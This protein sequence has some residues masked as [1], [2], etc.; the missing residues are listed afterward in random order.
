[1]LSQDDSFF[2]QIV[3]QL[4]EE[5]EGSET[6]MFLVIVMMKK[7]KVFVS[8]DILSPSLA[9]SSVCSMDSQSASLPIS[10][11]NARA[12]SLEELQPSKLVKDRVDVGESCTTI[13]MG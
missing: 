8:Q 1:M 4:S 3:Y 5:K 2:D 7:W 6:D 12:K 9:N 11:L 13:T 10:V